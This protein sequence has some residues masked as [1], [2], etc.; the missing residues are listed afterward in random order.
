[1]GTG[2]RLIIAAIAAWLLIGRADAK[3]LESPVS[4]IAMPQIRVTVPARNIRPQMWPGYF[5][6]VCQ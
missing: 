3:P 6:C 5:Y 4:P 2:L 1:M